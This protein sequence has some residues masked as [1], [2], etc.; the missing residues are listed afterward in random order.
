MSKSLPLIVLAASLSL[1]GCNKAPVTTDNEMVDVDN[2]ADADEANFD[3]A[4][5][6]ENAADS[7]TTAVTVAAVP[8]PAAKSA[9]T[10]PLA[11][12][13]AIEEDIRT[14]RGVERIRY[15]QGW[16]WTRA[17]RIVRTADRDGGNVAY[18]RDGSDRPFLVQRGGRAF[19]YDGDRPVR[20][21]DRDGRARTPDA[22]RSREASEAQRDAR[23]QRGRA[24]DARR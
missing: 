24:E 17:G 12:A 15:G 20:E 14:G 23:D 5:V 22:D 16:A 8:R 1:A 6:I 2:A 7:D 3:E 4:P 21:F 19:A 13:G 9:E 18:F 11:D 10:A